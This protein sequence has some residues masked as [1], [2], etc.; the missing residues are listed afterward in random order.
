MHTDFTYVLTTCGTSS[1]QYPYDSSAA[2]NTS[3]LHIGTITYVRILNE[4]QLP[5]HILIPLS[6]I[7]LPATSIGLWGFNEGTL[8]LLGYVCA[9]FGMVSWL[10]IRRPV[11]LPP[12]SALKTSGGR[13]TER[14]KPAPSYTTSRP[15]VVAIICNFYIT[16]ISYIRG[17]CL[18][19]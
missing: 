16:Y 19:G 11:L 6:H 2:R 9:R 1:T 17:L 14:S 5:K 15:S 8:G 10:N 4:R 7:S 18:V 12:S 13:S 3:P